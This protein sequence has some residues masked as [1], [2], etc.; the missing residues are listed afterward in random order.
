MSVEVNTLDLFDDLYFWAFGPPLQKVPWVFYLEI[1]IILPHFQYIS[2]PLSLSVHASV[3]VLYRWVM[4]QV[5]FIYLE[6]KG[7][8][9]LFGY[10]VR[11]LWR[12][13]DVIW[14]NVYVCMY[15]SEYHV[16]FACR[17]LP[18]SNGVTDWPIRCSFIARSIHNVAVFVGEFVAT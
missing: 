16:M 4:I 11:Q 15:V 12:P 14:G 8:A 10:F 18:L 3:C 6:L 17:P 13:L 7:W 9:L 1:S 5:F 2:F